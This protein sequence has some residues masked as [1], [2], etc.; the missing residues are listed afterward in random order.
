MSPVKRVVILVAVLAVITGAYVLLKDR[1]GTGDEQEFKSSYQKVVDLKLTEVE[2]VTVTN[3][4][5]T[6]VITRDEDENGWK[7]DKPADLNYD[8]SKVQ[9]VVINAYS[10]GS[11]KVIEEDAS[12]LSKFGFDNPVVVNVRTK[13]GNET[14]YELGAKT[15]GGSYYMR[16]KESTRVYKVDSYAG[17]RIAVK[18]NDL[19]KS[20]LFSVQPDEITQFSMER[21]GSV[22]FK[23]EKLDEYEWRFTYPI[24]GNLNA[25]AITP[26]LEAVSGMAV[27]EFV[28]ENVSDMSEYGLH[29][30]DYALAFRTSAGGEKKILLGYEKEKDREIYASLEGSNEVISVSLENLKFLDKP[31]R[32]IVEVFAYIVNI[33]DVSAIDVEMDGYKVRLDI[34]T[35]PDDKENDKFYVDS[36]LAVMEDENGDQ[37]FRKYYQAL[38][39][40]TLAEIDP[41]AQPEGEAEITFT[42]YLKKDPEIMKV[43]FIPKDEYYY[44]VVRN[45]EYSGVLVSKSKFDEPEGVRDS[46]DKLKKAIEQQEKE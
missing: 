29:T 45:G 37:P 18:K 6:F 4:E 5:D 30:A 21:G 42:Y 16:L 28:E 12:D 35:D 26:M 43:E 34:Q 17:D 40:V 32:E 9:S 13:D 2:K 14:V 3:G 8:S 41:D 23:A 25:S 19:R 24:K 33:N 7:L 20:E 36:K 15:P 44:Y 27:S 1:I 39:G 46:Y 38:I 11:S 10:V 22:L 31:L